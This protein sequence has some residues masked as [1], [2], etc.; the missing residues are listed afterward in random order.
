MKF[1]CFLWQ[2]PRDKEPWPAIYRDL[3]LAQTMPDR[4]SA[5]VE[6][7]LQVRDG[8]DPSPARIPS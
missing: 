8:K 7:E 6:I 4:V 3:Q 5:I 1:Y 2:R